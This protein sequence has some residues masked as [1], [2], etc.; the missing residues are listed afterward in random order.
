MA[1]SASSPSKSRPNGALRGFND[2][3]IQQLQ[4]H[5]SPKVERRRSPQPPPDQS[6]PPQS[7]SQPQSTSSTSIAESILDALEQLV[8]S[9][10]TPTTPPSVP[11]QPQS[12]TTD[13]ASSI[14]V[15]TSFFADA[16]Q[17]IF[18]SPL[19]PPIPLP[20]PPLPPS[21]LLPPP[22]PLPPPPSL[23]R[24][25]PRRLMTLSCATGHSDGDLRH[26]RFV[27]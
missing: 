17:T 3:S 12:T 10:S 9:R 1:R 16:S 18:L 4:R 25:P 11:P 21:P 13:T 24:C 14:R 19:P 27:P 15:G 26:E 8:A 6:A 7:P 2:A 20:P 22:P 5:V 23:K